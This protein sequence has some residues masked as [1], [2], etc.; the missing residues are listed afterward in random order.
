MT[1]PTGF[2]S[3]RVSDAAAN[4]FTGQA[5][6]G[7]NVSFGAA[8][9]IGG[10]SNSGSKLRAPGIELL[11]AGHL[12]LEI[13]L[14]SSSGHA[15]RVSRPGGRAARYSPPATA[16]QPAPCRPSGRPAERRNLVPGELPAVTGPK[17]GARPGIPRPGTGTLLTEWCRKAL[18][19]DWPKHSDRSLWG[20]P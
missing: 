15:S 7:S 17:G 13:Q 2:V 10:T 20:R 14:T 8:S 5:Y 16:R 9:V 12:H 11:Q 3:W 6:V 18:L 1:G 19:T 4:L